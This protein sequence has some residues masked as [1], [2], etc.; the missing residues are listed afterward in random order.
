[1]MDIQ[2]L[3]SNG[4]ISKLKNNLDKEIFKIHFFSKRKFFVKIRKIFIFETHSFQ[5][6]FGF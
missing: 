6:I 3:V 2:R 1:M 5:K 4:K